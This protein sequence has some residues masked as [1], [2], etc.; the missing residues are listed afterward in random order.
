MAPPL[1]SQLDEWRGIELGW[2][3][4]IQGNALSGTQPQPAINV[5]GNELRSLV[6]LL[7]S[8]GAPP[9]AECRAQRFA[10]VGQI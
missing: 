10:R 1:A 7:G 9:G 6:S 5:A 8:N 2:E 3:R 4:G